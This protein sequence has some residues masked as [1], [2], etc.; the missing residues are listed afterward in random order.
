[1]SGGEEVM[2]DA[3]TEEEEDILQSSTKRNKGSHA[4]EMV[5]GSSSSGDMKGVTQSG[6]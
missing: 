1:M 4:T 6:K 3:M 2:Q 5:V